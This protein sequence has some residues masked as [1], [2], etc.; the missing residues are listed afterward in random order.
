MFSIRS[1]LP[2]SASVSIPA[3]QSQSISTIPGGRKIETV[4]EKEGLL[5]FLGTKSVGEYALNILG[6]NVSRVT[7]GKKPYDILFLHEATKQDFDKKKTEFTFPGANR[8]YLQSSNTDVAAAAAISIA[9]TEMKTILPKD[10][11]PE[12]YNKIYLPGDGSAGLPLLKCGD[13]FLSP[14]DIV[15]RLVEHNLHEVEDIRLTSCHSANIT[16]NNDFSPEEIEKSTKS[17][18]GWLASALFGPKCSLAEH[19]YAEFESRGIS[20]SISGYHG[21]GVFYVP[22]HGKPT[23]HLRSTTVP[24]T[25]EQTV[26]RSDYRLSLG[27]TQPTDID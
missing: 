8:S 9:A 11:T 12:K 19:V 7:T 18:S 24:A 27:R 23:T 2:I 4:P 26:R 25:P 15:N 20:V 13:E 1:Q 14:T 16:K 3:E 17:S 5:V 21:T 6:Q 22:E 10:L